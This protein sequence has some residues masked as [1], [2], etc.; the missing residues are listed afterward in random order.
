MMAAI[1]NSGVQGNREV[2]LVRGDSVGIERVVTP[3]ATLHFR[4]SHPSDRIEDISD[5]VVMLA[6]LSLNLPMVRQRNLSQTQEA[7]EEDPR[8][9]SCRRNLNSNPGG[10]DSMGFE[11]VSSG[12]LRLFDVLSFDHSFASARNVHVTFFEIDPCSALARPVSNDHIT[13]DLRKYSNC[14]MVLSKNMSK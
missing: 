4:G 9:G 8:A 13:T 3:K 5:I 14:Q 12:F 2:A 10:V 6:N 11:I 1:G 7:G